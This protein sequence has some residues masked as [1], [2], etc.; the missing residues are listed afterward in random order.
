MAMRL[1]IAFF[2]V[3]SAVSTGLGADNQL[4]VPSGEY[5]TIQSAINA[6]LEGDEVIVAE[7][8][9]LENLNF[10][11][12]AIT[13]SSSDPNDP[14]VVQNTIID[15]SVPEDPNFGSV[16]IFNSG[17]EQNSVLEGFTITGGTGSWIVVSWEFKGLRWNRCGGGV[18]CY[19]MSAPTVRKN[20]FQDNMA[21]QGGGITFTVIRLIRRI[22]A[23]RRCI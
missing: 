18:L 14:N 2:L 4:L 23:T 15:G 22:R 7:G 11:G 21:G 13:V 3:I 20:I 6:A 1:N 9:Y 19:N 17:E 5:S 16:V 8:T 12:K 10:Q